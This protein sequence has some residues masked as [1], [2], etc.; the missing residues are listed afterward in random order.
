[1]PRCTARTFLVLSVVLIIALSGCGGGGTRRSE[2]PDDPRSPRIWTVLVYMAADNSLESYGIEDINEMETIG[3]TSQATVLVQI[4]R[5]P[6]GDAGNGDWTTTRRYRITQDSDEALIGSELLA[7]LGELNMA[8]P[9]TL[10]DFV[11][12]GVRNYPAQHYLLVL[13]DHGQGW[14]SRALM[15]QPR[16]VRA[17]HIDE[18]SGMDD[19][20]LP[21]LGQA[22]A[23]LPRMD[24]VLFDACLMG[25]LE[26]A[27]SI[28]NSADIMIASEE[29]IPVTG[30]P[31]QSLVRRLVYDPNIEPGAVASAVVDDYI[32]HYA[33]ISSPCT[34]S[35][36]NLTRLGDLVTAT[37]DLASAMTSE[38]DAWRSEI[39]LAAEQTQHFQSDRVGN[40]TY[41]DYR[42][43]YDFA[44]RVRGSVLSVPLRTAAS[45]VISAIDS[46]VIAQRNTGGS[47]AN[48]H[49]VSIYLPTPGTRSQALL[50]QYAGISFGRDT[51]WDEFLAAY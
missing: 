32:S 46:L 42:D 43:L 38:V 48:S 9:A 6:G 22:F 28:A 17:I 7:D 51:Q 47:V 39:R 19:M 40:S 1:M 31:Y 41:T 15:A 44:W 18:T 50:T 8:D 13:W 37:D 14:Q 49:G 20:S 12:W 33:G 5:K 16:E 34:L 35:A 24:I 23:P 45:N 11:Q 30:Q 29:E 27:H 2:I 4:D 25:M 21:E 10:T 36:L 26:V 3:S